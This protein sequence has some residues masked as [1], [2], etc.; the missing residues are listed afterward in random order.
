MQMIKYLLT[1][2][3]RANS[4]SPAS[5]AKT[6][7]R[8]MAGA[9]VIHPARKGIEGHDTLAPLP[10]EGTLGGWRLDASS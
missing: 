1:L 8:F 6:Y 5:S 2:A 7:R 3:L 10:N 9:S 4:K